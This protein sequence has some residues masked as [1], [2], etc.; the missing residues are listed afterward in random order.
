[1]TNKEDFFTADNINY[2]EWKKG[3]SIN[4][5]DSKRVSKTSGKKYIER[6]WYKK[7]E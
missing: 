3:D 5:I 2:R 7:F 1:M 6:Y 4:S